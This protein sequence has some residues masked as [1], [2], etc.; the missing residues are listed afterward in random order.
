MIS[1]VM[2][3]R[4][5]ANICSHSAYIERKCENLGRVE[6]FSTSNHDTGVIARQL[7]CGLWQRLG[8]GRWPWWCGAIKTLN[9]YYRIEYS[10][11]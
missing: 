7:A 9:R 5:G 2:V 8:V 11:M 1:C 3:A 10:L 6:I 4:V